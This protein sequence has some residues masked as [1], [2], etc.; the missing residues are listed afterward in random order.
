MEPPTVREST[1]ALNRDRWYFKPEVLANSPSIQA[2]MTPEAEL[3]NRQ[4]AAN[5]IQDMGQ[6][7]RV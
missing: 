4:Q 5:M 7:L 6:R 3:S 2:G 1:K